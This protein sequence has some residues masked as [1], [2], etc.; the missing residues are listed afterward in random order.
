[1]IKKYML[2]AFRRTTT[3]YGINNSVQTLHRSFTNN[4]QSDPTVETDKRRKRPQTSRQT[5][6]VLHGSFFYLEHYNS[7]DSKQML[8]EHLHKI[9]YNVGIQKMDKFCHLLFLIKRTKWQ[10]WSAS[11]PLDL[12]ADYHGAELEWLHQTRCLST[13]WKVQDTHYNIFHSS[14]NRF[15]I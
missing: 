10:T 2:S 11:R 1:M 5:A 7:D 13:L 3:C 9:P 14:I 4:K 15:N 12:S 6:A 8:Y